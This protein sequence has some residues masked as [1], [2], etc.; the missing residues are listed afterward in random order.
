VK[1]NLEKTIKI[2]VRRAYNNYMTAVES[3]EASQIQY[4]AGELAFRTQQES[5][6]LGISAQVAVALA[7]QTFVQAASSKAQAEI[8]LVFQKMLLDYALGTLN[9]RSLME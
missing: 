8:T 4:R 3:Y 2:D 9:P 7:N 6:I 5:F 1:D